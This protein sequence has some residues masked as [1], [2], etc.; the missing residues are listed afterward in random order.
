MKALLESIQLY[1]K[2]AFLESK[3]SIENYIKRIV[4]DSHPPRRLKHIIKPWQMD[5]YKVLIPLFEAAA[6]FPITTDKKAAFI[7]AGKGSSKTSMIAQLVSW[8]LCFAKRKI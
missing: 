2:L 5:L 4:V 8:V 7:T 1:D 6:G 3:Q